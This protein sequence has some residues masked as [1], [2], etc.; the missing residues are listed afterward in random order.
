MERLNA[1]LSRE[2]PRL[3]RSRP[4]FARVMVGATFGAGLL[5][6]LTVGIMGVF[7]L[8]PLGNPLKALLIVAL[9]CGAIIPP[10]VLYEKLKLRFVD[11]V[12]VPSW[13]WRITRAE[14]EALGGE[15]PRPVRLRLA[16][17]RAK[18]SVEWWQTL[19]ET[20]AEKNVAALIV[21][22]ESVSNRLRQLW[23]RETGVSFPYLAGFMVCFPML[24]ARFLF[25]PSVQEFFVTMIGAIFGASVW[26]TW[27]VWW[28][29]KSEMQ[30]DQLLSTASPDLRAAMVSLPGLG[31][32][33]L[34]SVVNLRDSGVID[35]E[36]CIFLGKTAEAA[37]A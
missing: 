36:E 24:S 35:D 8:Q 31:R 12:F 1:R 11:G 2:M 37:Y 29:S 27:M 15:I 7:A 20:S 25:A 19:L 17:V 33:F 32:I 30:A 23:L 3:V 14:F 5:F 26:V 4:I 10:I 18:R 34:R 28:H 9:S 21:S 6:S 16:G 22:D 13:L